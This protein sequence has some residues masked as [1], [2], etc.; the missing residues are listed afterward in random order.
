MFRRLILTVCCLLPSI[1]VLAGP[2][3][4]AVPRSVIQASSSPT[5]PVPSSSTTFDFGP[6]TELDNSVA[7]LR[8]ADGHVTG[9]A[10]IVTSDGFLLT[11][12]S[13][14]SDVRMYGCPMAA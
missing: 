1:L 5:R 11:D 12:S 4:A 7:M 8:K 3:C 9:A 10:V 14:L 13:A 2:G 6:T